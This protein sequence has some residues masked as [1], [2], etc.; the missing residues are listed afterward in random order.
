MLLH[1]PCIFLW[2]RLN[3][4]KIKF[5]VT[6][7]SNK[8]TCDII[9]RKSFG[10]IFPFGCSATQASKAAWTSALSFPLEL[11]R[12]VMSSSLNTGF[13]FFDPILI[14]DA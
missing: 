12:L 9:S 7:Q 1:L 3:K 5:F 6:F 13:P 2:K 10:F 14:A 8:L 11:I 4:V